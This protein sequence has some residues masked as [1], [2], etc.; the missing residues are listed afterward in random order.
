MSR[1]ARCF[2]ELHELAVFCPS[3]NQPH[4]PAFDQLLNQLI[5][6]RYQVYRRLGQGGMSAVFTAL[7]QQTDQVV[8]VK[9]SDPSQL[10]KRELTYALDAEDARR[11]WAEML[12]RM[13]REAEI[14]T[15]I[16]HPNIVQLYDT[17]TL[18]EDLRYVVLEY[19]RGRSLRD[20]LAARRKLP[21]AEALS[22]AITLADALREIHAR[23]IVHRD[24]N[25]RNVMLCPETSTDPA[26]AKRHKPAK[27]L[28]LIDFGIAKFPQPPGA[29]P[30]T[31][32]SILS[33]TVAYA[34]PEQCQNQPLDQRADLYSLGIVLY[35]MLTGER[36]FAGRT[37]TEIALNQIQQP[38]RP[39]RELLPELPLSLESALL[40]VLAK[41]PADRQANI[42]ELADE[43][44]AIAQRVVVPLPENRATEM[45]SPLG[46]APEPELPLTV[47]LPAQLP[48]LQLPTQPLPA[49]PEVAVA[50]E[51]EFLETY[52]HAAPRSRHAMVYALVGLCLLTGAALLASG[53][54]AG[55]LVDSPT[56][57]QAGI[58]KNLAT[59]TEPEQLETPNPALAPSPSPQPAAAPEPTHSAPEAQMAFETEP[60]A[61]RQTAPKAPLK[62]G[63][64]LAAKPIVPIVLRSPSPV[65]VP[66]PAPA[67]REPQIFSQPEP[68]PTPSRPGR[69]EP[70]YTVVTNF[71][72]STP[73][74][75]RQRRRAGRELPDDNAA[76][77]SP[78]YDPEYDEDRVEPSAAN[79]RTENRREN[80]DV[81]EPRRPVFSPRVIAWSGAVRGE[82]IIRLEMP[83][84]PGSVE[85]PRGYRRRVG[86][87]EPPSLENNW[88]LVALRVQGRG[89][90]SII[91]RWWPK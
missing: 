3:C 86:I 59:P 29:P 7:D 26:S 36:P 44:R 85:I 14:L 18:N 32:H 84:V 46:L 80:E 6:E 21:L 67:A 22:Y 64:R 56:R 12:E 17:G 71:P 58:A 89:E 55:S 33:G 43:L 47:P 82:R 68:L 50:V 37:P 45:V 87:V 88:R 19:L 49:Q 77:A 66:L 48:V 70:E 4:S 63:P 20:E 28:K 38:P 90:V 16:R 15:Q 39:P 81:F 76:P 13:R 42:V 41:N 65:Y 69:V 11:Y 57:D 1:C 91:L 73:N 2:G 40:R 8:V 52:R 72:S 51:P 25:P 74:A 79:R 34:S 61:Y 31:Q 5:G 62:P 53:R 83:G 54:F 35:E 75:G 30:F 9:F 27:V 60:L 78:E 24:L 23:G 10:A